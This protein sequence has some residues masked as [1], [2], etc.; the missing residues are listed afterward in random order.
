MP[1]IW[2]IVNRKNNIGSESNTGSTDSNIFETGTRMDLSMQKYKIDRFEHLSVADAYFSCGHQHITPESHFDESPVYD[3]STGILFTADMFLT[4]RGAII[5]RL[6]EA[7]ST[8][9]FNHIGDVKLAF[10]TYLAFGDSFTGILRG[11]FSI[12][13]YHSKE[14]KLQLFTDHIG[15]RYLA[16][17]VSEDSI[18]FGSVYTP[19]FE[20]LGGRPKLCEE[21]M[22]DL[23]LDVAPTSFKVPSL[24]VYSG[25]Y[26]VNCAECVTIDCNSGKVDRNTYYTLNVK[27]PYLK[28]N[29]DE[30]YKQAFLKTY[31]E[32]VE[33]L[34][35]SDKE[36]AVELSGGLDSSS[37]AALAATA[38]AKQNKKLYSFT[39]V[40]SSDYPFTNNTEII[41]NEKFTVEPQ[42]RKQPNIEPAFIA[43]E[44]GCAF[45]DVEKYTDMFEVPVKTIVNIPY[46]YQFAYNASEKGCKLMLAGGNG[47]A[48]ISYGSIFWYVTENIKR[49]RFISAYKEMRAYCTRNKISQKQF[50]KVVINGYYERI[51]SRVHHKFNSV[52]NSGLVEKYKLKKLSRRRALARGS[53]IIQNRRERKNF[54]FNVSLFTHMGFYQTYM[55]LLTGVLDVDAT[56]TKELIEF[57]FSL[58]ID[59]F[60]KN[61]RERRTIRDYMADLLPESVTSEYY[62]RGIQSA[63][64][65]FRI[66]REWPGIS[67][68]VI[69]RLESEKLL[70]YCDQE[71]LKDLIGKIKEKNGIKGRKTANLCVTLYALD[72]FLKTQ[73]KH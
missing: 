4:N 53:S 1:A 51:C 33:M 65:E 15:H 57:C 59:I 3:E 18:C 39:S 8:A 16:Y 24:T 43:Q 62:G 32:C 36:T 34:L 55:N 21:C 71:Q 9:D 52:I 2:G 38:L 35:R 56:M 61:G 42:V 14:N 41:E 5:E 58:P 11:Y 44:V 54:C 27:A 48:T 63:D 13:I 31:R 12:A 6:K 40:P 47:N 28:L 49:F 60:V 37:T 20:A 17:H 10:L 23:Y 64:C 69:A 45:S 70:K 68:D 22:A 67:A 50:A 73:E 19:I 46:L 72:V 7:G 26:H 30:K 25:I 66:A 29:S